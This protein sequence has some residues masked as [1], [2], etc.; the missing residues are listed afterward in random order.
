MRKLLTCFGII[1]LLGHCNTTHNNYPTAS[2][3]TSDKEYHEVM[4]TYKFETAEVLNYL[5][6]DVSPENP[7]TAITIENTS[8][9]NIVITVS[10][11]NSY[12]KKIPIAVGK[13]GSV[14]IPKNQTYRLSGMVCKS[15]YQTS[16]Y[17]TNAY[18]VKLSD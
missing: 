15:S 5:L 2:S 16:K 18:S 1:L 11:G 14:M 9:C 3:S 4:K 7:K 8:R 12:Y 6:N 13:I 10:G 17:I